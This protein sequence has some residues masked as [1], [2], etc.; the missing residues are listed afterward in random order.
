MICI[1]MDKQQ[2]QAEDERP[3][4]KKYNYPRIKFNHIPVKP[5]TFSDFRT[6]RKKYHFQTDELFMR[7]LVDNCEVEEG[8]E[9]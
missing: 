1:E 5:K 6:M 4:K 3:V 8:E 2:E 7:Y 9:R